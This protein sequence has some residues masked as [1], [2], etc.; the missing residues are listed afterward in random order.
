[1]PAVLAWIA[2]STFGVLSVNTDL[3]SG[4][5]A[6]IAGGV[7]VSALGSGAVAALVYLTAVAAVP[8]LVDPPRSQRQPRRVPALVP[9]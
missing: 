2:G 4:P 6:D 7:D 1:M 3:V 5:L 8:A 9:A